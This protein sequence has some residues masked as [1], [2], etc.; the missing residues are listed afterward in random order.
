MGC[1]MS[2]DTADALKGLW[3]VSMTTV[4]DP[5][6]SGFAIILRCALNIEASFL[7]PG[8]LA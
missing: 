1:L 4:T 3:R 5:G 2:S 7:F 6:V 8:E